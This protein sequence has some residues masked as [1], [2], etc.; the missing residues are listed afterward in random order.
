MPICPTCNRQFSED[1]QTCPHDG[2]TLVEAQD[3]RA[4]LKEY[5]GEPSS[6]SDDLELESAETLID[7]SG[8]STAELSKKSKNNATSKPKR[9]Q[10]KKTPAP[11]RGP[12]KTPTRTDRPAPLSDSK[13]KASMR[14][15]SPRETLDPSDLVGQRLFG[16]YTIQS[17]LGEGGMGAVYLAQQDSIEQKIAVKVLHE[18]SAES[19]ELV[20]RFHRE[21]QVV[22]MITH[23]NII[24]VF[25]FGRTDQDLLY[26]AMEYVNGVPLREVL[27]REQ[28]LDEMRAIKILKQ[29]CSGL[30]EAHDLGIIHRDLKPD[31]VL[32]TEWRGEKDFAKILDFGIAKIKQ[33]QGQQEQK[34]L[35]QAGIVYGTPEYLSPEQAQAMDLDQRTDI[36]SLGCI[37][38]EMMTG[39]LPFSAKTPV[40]IL[41]A[42]VFNDPTPPSEVAPDRVSPTM[43]N[44]ILKAMA[45]EPDERFQSAMDMFEA[46]VAR[47][48]EI[49][50]EQKLEGRPGYVPGLEL[51]GMYSAVDLEE[52]AL[53]ASSNGNATTAA[54]PAS[55]SSAD[56]A[57]ASNLSASSSAKNSSTADDNT[58]LILYLL[59]AAIGLLAL[60]LVGAI[61]AY[62]LVLS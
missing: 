44:I 53:K 9:Q 59:G 50:R 46:L 54:T 38:Y 2:T 21:A 15:A 7:F 14:Q 33:P 5:G 8:P 3:G 11:A 24:R 37:L 19:D 22:S 20:Q 61:G 62:L 41:T 16:E 4:T 31:N 34:K 49:V 45:K 60:L 10:P 36:Y 32:L 43:Q 17:K 13:A 25:I 28:L 26:L 56:T 6:S 1:I 35:T 55:T 52:K 39:H 18:E 30:S 57:T 48:Q 47:E 58:R 23:P 51:T 12:K 27:D 40:K 42:H 29:I